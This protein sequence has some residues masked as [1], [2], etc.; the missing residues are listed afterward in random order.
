[1]PE[2][3]SEGGNRPADHITGAHLAVL[4]DVDPTDPL[5]AVVG[6]GRARIIVDW[7][8]D[9][10]D[11][12]RNLRDLHTGKPELDPW[13]EDVPVIPVDVITEV[14]TDHGVKVP[15]R[16]KRASSPSRAA[17]PIPDRVVAGAHGVRPRPDRRRRAPRTHLGAGVGLQR[18]ALR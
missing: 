13:V 12:G 1:M 17:P 11:H 14:F 6:E 9:T 4:L 3:T 18:S 8:R 15:M 10:L 16:R 7:Q 5:S 2:N